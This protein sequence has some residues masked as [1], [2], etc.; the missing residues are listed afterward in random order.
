[1]FESIDAINVESILKFQANEG[2]HDHAH[3]VARD[4]MCYQLT[5]SGYTHL[6]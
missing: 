4:L 2:S 6:S 1:M 5:A 3:L